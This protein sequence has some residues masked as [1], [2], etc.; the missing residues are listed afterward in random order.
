MGEHPMRCERNTT[1]L[2][3]T[4]Q[5]KSSV[6]LSRRKGVRSNTV[7]DSLSGLVL[8]CALLEHVS[9]IV[10][11]AGGEFLGI[12][13][14]VPDLYIEALALFKSENQTTLALRISECTVD[15]VRRALSE[16]DQRFLVAQNAQRLRGSV[17]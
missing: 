1:S 13:P 17:L 8:D 10:E 15:S 6:F 4:P 2:F 9:A 11:S 12:Q 5:E 7:T 14:G 16:S 3:K